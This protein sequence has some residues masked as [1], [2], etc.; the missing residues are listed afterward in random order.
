MLSIRIALASSA[1]IVA[2]VSA[3]RIAIAARAPGLRTAIATGASVALAATGALVAAIASAQAQAPPA[4]NGASLLPAQTT[5]SITPTLSPDRLGAKGSL[6]VTIRY[7]GGAFGVPS[8]V[9][10]AVLELPAGLDLEIPSLHSCAAGR[11]LARGP[12]GCPARSK[13]GG[14]RALAEV[15]A[16][17]VNISESASLWAFLGPLQGNLEPT[18]E[19]LAQG[20]TPVDKRTVL[21]GTVLPAHEPYGEELALAIP[22]IPTLMFEPDA[23]IISF[24]LTIGKAEPHLPPG[25]DTIV[26]PSSCPTG[27][28]PFAAEFTYAEGSTGTALA[29]VPCP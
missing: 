7:A 11:L 17:T 26:V 29:T 5:A 24:S 15:H 6:T 21:S 16:G 9:R 22:P 25:A 19:I 8:P 3:V 4:S 18:F 14:G 12:S 27:G 28:F 10:K 23:S 1:R 13:L 2:R 20:Y